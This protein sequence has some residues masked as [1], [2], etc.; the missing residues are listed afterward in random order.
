MQER[1]DPT[2][3]SLTGCPAM[4]L[5]KQ[6]D[7]PE[8]NECISFM[9]YFMATTYKERER[10]RELEHQNAGKQ[11]EGNFEAFDRTGDGNKDTLG[12]DTTGDGKADLFIE[13]KTDK[14]GTYEVRLREGLS[15]HL[16]LPLP[17]H[18]FAC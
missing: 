18:A 4:L 15:R 2:V 17:P 9:R 1:C 5:A 14:C 8:H 11:L 13:A 6:Y 7:T 12:V 16:R 10:I 3:C